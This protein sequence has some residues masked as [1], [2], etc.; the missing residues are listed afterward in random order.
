MHHLRAARPDAA[1]ADLMTA[2]PTRTTVAA[3]AARWGFA[4]PGRFAA[5][6]QQAYGETPAATLRR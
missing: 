5:A 4:N 3:M 6:Y 1:R 2:D